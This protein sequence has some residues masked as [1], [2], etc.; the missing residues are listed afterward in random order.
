MTAAQDTEMI[1]RTSI[2]PRLLGPGICRCQWLAASAERCMDARDWRCRRGITQNRNL[3]MR[4][5][6]GSRRLVGRS[7]QSRGRSRSAAATPARRAQPNGLSPTTDTAWSARRPTPW[8]RAHRSRGVCCARTTWIRDQ[9][10]EAFLDHT[11][12]VDRESLRV[13]DV[14]A[15]S[16]LRAIHARERI[17]RR[18]PGRLRNGAAALVLAGRRS[19]PLPGRSLPRTARTASSYAAPVSRPCHPHDIRPWLKDPSLIGRTTLASASLE[20]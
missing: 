16:R 5:W 15:R 12:W 6:P 8:R 14:P 2:A 19:R 4:S 13:Y 1:V 18:R 9:L 3:P 11:G 10:A 17:L 20:I 7:A